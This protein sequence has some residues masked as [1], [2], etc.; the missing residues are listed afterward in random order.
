MKSGGHQCLA[1]RWIWEQ[2]SELKVDHAELAGPWVV[3]DVAR[4][5]IIVADAKVLLELS[6]K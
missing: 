1:L 2:S 3:G 6:E 4:F 5:W